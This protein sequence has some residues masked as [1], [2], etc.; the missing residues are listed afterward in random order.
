MSERIIFGAL[1]GATIGFGV[2]YL[3]ARAGGS[4]PFICNPYIAAGL[5]LALGAL[6]A[7]SSQSSVRDYTP[8]AHLL[9]PDSAEV[10]DDRIVNSET[11]ALVEFGRPGCPH[12]RRLEP[13]MHELADEYENDATIAIVD[14]TEIPDV[15][16]QYDIGAVP[17]LILYD[18]GEV[19]EQVVGYRDKKALQQMLDNHLETR[20]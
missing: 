14:T 16:R 11:P 10:F 2:G 3:G 8:S 5:G 1:L 9:T 7:S 20:E 13:I 12:C 17:T 19:A 18:N 4:C 15:A 6:F